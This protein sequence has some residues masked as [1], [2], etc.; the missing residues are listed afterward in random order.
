MCNT[1]HGLGLNFKMLMLYPHNIFAMDAIPHY[2]LSPDEVNCLPS[3]N[4]MCAIWMSTLFR[5]TDKHSGK[6][7]FNIESEK[8]DSG[9]IAPPA[10]VN[11]TL[12]TQ[13]I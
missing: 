13:I 12:G 9:N 7:T 4:P 6:Q 11:I 5:L 1:T 3:K 10:Y 8:W 2:S